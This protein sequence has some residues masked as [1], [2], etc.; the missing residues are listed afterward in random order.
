[1]RVGSAD[2][3]GFIT[4]QPD[5]KDDVGIRFSVS[6]S[7]GEFTVENTKIWIETVKF[8]HFVSDFIELEQKRQGDIRLQ[9]MSPEEYLLRIFSLDNQGHM[10]LSMIRR[11]PKY[12]SN[13]IF[14][15]HIEVA[16][17]IDPEFMN[18]FAKEIKELNETS[19]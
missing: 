13:K 10:G 8:D 7:N 2:K 18:Q 3:L 17:E 9:C 1:M 5:E 19:K 16:F 4:L 14:W 11:I 15:Q 12:Y 6:G